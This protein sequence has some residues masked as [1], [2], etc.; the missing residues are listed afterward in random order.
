MR[1]LVQT[2]LLLA[3]LI[4]AVPAAGQELRYGPE[5]PLGNGTAR[6]YLILSDEGHPLE[7]GFA[8]SESA[9]EGLPD[10]A[11]KPDEE[12]FLLIDLEMPEGNPTPFRL[13][14]LDWN[15][16]GHVPPMY[17]LP[18]FDFHF[19]LIDP[20]TRDAILPADPDDYASFEAR[21]ILP[22]VEGHLPGDYVYAP[23]STIPRMG[24]HWIDPASHELHGAGFDTTYLYGTWDGSVIFWE[25]MMTKAYIE[26]RPDA[27]IEIA[28]PARVATPGWYPSAYRVGFDDESKEYRI[29][30]V[31][32]TER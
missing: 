29:A 17:Q 31:G 30:L 18:H 10:L 22:V 16:R 3:L 4:A 20:E 21:G 8:L 27:V 28:T 11:D 13:A 15:P 7:L 23:A 25:P 32:F 26:S 2:T 19:Y 9:L 24:A 12:A 1:P 5:S 14:A 6:A